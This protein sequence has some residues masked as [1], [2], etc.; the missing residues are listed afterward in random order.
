REQ[1]LCEC[2]WSA[3]GP[4]QPSSAGRHFGWA[5]ALVAERWLLFRVVPTHTGRECRVTR[6]QRAL[7]DSACGSARSYASLVGGDLRWSNRTVRRGCYRAGWIEH[8]SGRS[9]SDEREEP[10]WIVRDSQPADSRQRRQLHGG[11]ARTLRRGS[12]QYQR[13]PEPEWCGQI[14]REVLLFELESRRAVLRRQRP[15]VP[16]PS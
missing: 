16:G 11:F 7:P 1:L 5:F 3:Q 15:R 10:R 6:E 13:R 4:V 8:Q 12:V 14:V 2:D 9:Q